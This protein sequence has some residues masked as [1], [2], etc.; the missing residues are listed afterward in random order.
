MDLSAILEII[1]LVAIVTFIVLAIFI[2][3][4]LNSA[5]KLID[6]ASKSLERLSSNLTE[7]M[8]QIQIDMDDLKDRVGNSLYK[9]DRLADSLAT[10]SEKVETEVDKYIQ[11]ISPLH[12]LIKNSYNRIALPISSSVITLSAIFKAINTFTNHFSKK[13]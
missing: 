9:F 7:S 10:T 13:K 4:T 6:E 3:I 12:N 11:T 1:S 2:I 5:T 8:K